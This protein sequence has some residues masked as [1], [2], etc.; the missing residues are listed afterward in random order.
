MYIYSNATGYRLGMRTGGASAVITPTGSPLVVGTT[1]FVV[2]EYNFSASQATLYLNSTPGAA[3]PAA[4]LTLTPTTAPTAIAN[5]GVKSQ[6]AVGASYI[7]DNMLVGTT[8]ADVTP[9]PE[10]STL[11]LACLGGLGLFGFTMRFRRASR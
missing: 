2:M 9:A 4:D 11:A 10:P 8:W 7:L 1:Y 3:Q 5:V 6:A